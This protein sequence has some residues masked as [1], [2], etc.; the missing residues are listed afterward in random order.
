MCTLIPRRLSAPRFRHNLEIELHTMSSLSCYKRSDYAKRSIIVD[1][2]SIRYLCHLRRSTL[3]G[4]ALYIFSLESINRPKPAHL[5]HSK[6]YAEFCTWCLF[7]ISNY[8]IRSTSALSL[9][10]KRG[11][12]LQLYSCAWCPNCSH[13]KHV[14][15]L[16]SRYGW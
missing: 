15:V 14:F 16:R 10:S 1:M 5:M 9:H 11:L 8:S 3:L 4:A 6:S 12:L 13:I 2:A 7:W